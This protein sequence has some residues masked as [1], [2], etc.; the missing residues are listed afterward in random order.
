MLPKDFKPYYFIYD[1]DKKIRFGL[2][3]VWIATK[4][5]ESLK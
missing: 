3:V 5:K 4:V 1:F 2:W